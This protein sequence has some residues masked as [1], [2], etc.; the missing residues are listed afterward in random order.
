MLVPNK[1]NDQDIAMIEKYMRVNNYPVVAN[2]LGSLDRLKAHCNKQLADLT[3]FQ[4]D[5]DLE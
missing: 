3:E 4:K 1:L 2:M 5:C